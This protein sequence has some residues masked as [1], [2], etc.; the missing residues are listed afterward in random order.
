MVYSFTSARGQ[1]PAGLTQGD[2][3][4]M[5]G[6]RQLTGGQAWVGRHQPTPMRVTRSTV[7]WWHVGE[8]TPQGTLD[9][10]GQAF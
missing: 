7:R 4:A 6:A 1:I 10:D 5:Q 9:T 3:A 2:L 8:A